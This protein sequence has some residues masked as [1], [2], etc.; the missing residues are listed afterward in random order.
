MVVVGIKEN[1]KDHS[2]LPTC[3]CH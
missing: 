3:K 1:R 2:Y